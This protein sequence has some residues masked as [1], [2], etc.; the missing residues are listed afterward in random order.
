[1]LR[2]L[3]KRLS[4]VHAKIPK[5]PS[6][7]E[8]AAFLELLAYLDSLAARK[9]SGDKTA[10]ADIEAVSALLKCKTD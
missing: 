6:P 5:K 2:T 3:R 9:A 7:D 10:H 1:M 8:E 4:S